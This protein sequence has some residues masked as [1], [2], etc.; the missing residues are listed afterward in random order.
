[1]LAVKN[2][3]KFVNLY[4][5]ECSLFEDSE[6]ALATNVLGVPNDTLCINVWYKRE[7]CLYFKFTPFK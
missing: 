3:F 2:R 5:N 6:L 4:W 7:K 1:M